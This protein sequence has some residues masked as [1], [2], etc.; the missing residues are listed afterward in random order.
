MMRKKIS[1]SVQIQEVKTE[2]A[3]RAQVYPRQIQQQ[4]GKR[5]ELE[6]RVDILRAVLATLE[7]LLENEE[8]VR[9]SV[10]ASGPKVESQKN[11]VESQAPG[12]N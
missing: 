9:A 4:P 5:S 2:L 8:V 12:E 7:W 10:N 11:P 3:L 6:Y 1:L